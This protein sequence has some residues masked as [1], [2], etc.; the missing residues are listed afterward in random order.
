MP[1]PE[2]PNTQ[3]ELYPMTPQLKE[4]S[5]EVRFFP[6]TEVIKIVG[7]GESGP[8]SFTAALEKLILIDDP[9]DKAEV[10]RVKAMR[11]AVNARAVELGY[12]TSLV[13]PGDEFQIS[14]DV[15]KIKPKRKSSKPYSISIKPSELGFSGRVGFETIMERKDIAEETR[16]SWRDLKEVFERGVLYDVMKATGLNYTNAVRKNQWSHMQSASGLLD[17]LRKNRQLKNIPDDFLS[18]PYKKTA[19]QNIAMVEFLKLQY[20]AVPESAPAAA[21]S[22]KPEAPATAPKM[23]KEAAPP[24][25]E[26]PL[27]LDLPVPGESGSE[28]P[29]AKK[30]DLDLPLPGEQGSTKAGPA[31]E[32]PLD[33]DLPFPGEPSSGSRR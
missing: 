9:R 19:E 23:P 31:V 32:V 13:H 20:E 21:A 8:R 4:A 29:P 15:L 1:S 2:K 30:P 25:P 11:K 22:A 7:P 12:N 14:F 33:L 6:D 10:K 5:K 26:K 16:R 17:K 28:P 3:A 24:T 18:Q 27:N